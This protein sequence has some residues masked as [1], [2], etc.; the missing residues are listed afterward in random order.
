MSEVRDN[1]TAEI[2][3]PRATEAFMDYVRAKFSPNMI[4]L[5]GH[6]VID[7]EEQ[8]RAKAVELVTLQLFDEEIGEITL[9]EENPFCWVFAV[10][11]IGIDI[12]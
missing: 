11:L 12:P 9:L 2:V 6:R 4:E 7:S 1:R 8:A 10:Q 5:M 3:V